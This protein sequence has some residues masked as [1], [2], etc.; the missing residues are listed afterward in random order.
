MSALRH[1][2]TKDLRQLV[3][4]RGLLALL[5]GY[6]LV[7][8]ALVAVALQGGERK[9]VVAFVN[10][11]TSGRTLQVGD[12]RIG[13]ADYENRLAEEV[14]LERMGGAEAE[15]ALRDGRVSAVITIPAGFITL[16]ES[17]IRPPVVTVQQSRRSPIEAQAITR[18]L[19]SAVYR[20][21]QDLA[22]TYIA[23]TLAL[24]DI[25]VNGGTVN[26]FGRD[27]NVLGLKRSDVLVKELQAQLR[28]E[29]KPEIAARMDA[30]SGFVREAS[31]NLDL[32]DLATSAIASPI[33]LRVTEATGGREALSGFGFAGALLVSLALVGV[34]LGA[35]A[36]SAEREE[37]TLV[38]LRRGLVSMPG[39]VAEKV[40][41]GAILCLAI[42]T[43][44]VAAVA[45]VSA[46]AVGRWGIWPVALLVAGIAF[47][48]FG[49]LIGALARDT[50]TALLA[51]LMLALPL[52]F[53]GLFTQ[54][55]AAGLISDLAPFG[56]AF[57]VFQMLIVEPSLDAATLWSRIGQLALLGT[58]FG[59]AASLVL[60]RRSET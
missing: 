37:N 42:G 60:R 14:E 46:L 6:P 47:T 4:S 28:R 16:L 22:R 50:R 3:R 5:I 27:G 8:A 49:V 52:V 1:L 43:V 38:R 21:N 2:L 58:A 20:L 19:E 7:V 26:L 39:L 29:G 32:A 31:A 51:A 10:A 41:F 9:P 44:L 18:R 57:R 59:M 35:A 25:V 23:Q 11:D 55:R 40:A 33:E 48:A 17:G 15:R 24:V 56:P 30:L 45:V 34:L 36:L 12:R 13:V 54:S 53:L